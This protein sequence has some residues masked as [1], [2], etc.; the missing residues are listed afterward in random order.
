MQPFWGEI[1]TSTERTN[2][3]RRLH[4]VWSSDLALDEILDEMAICLRCRHKPGT[5]YRCDVCRGDPEKTRGCQC[6]GT[7]WPKP[8]ELCAASGVMVGM[9]LEDILTIA[10][11]M[12]LPPERECE[13]Y[14]PTEAE[15]R[16]AKAR[17]RLGHSD[18]Q[19][20]AAMRGT[21]S[22]GGDNPCED[23][24]IDHEGASGSRHPRRKGQ[25]R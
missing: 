3:K 8:C 1:I 22:S 18:A 2:L 15:I 20:E 7:G 24:R 17:I 23:H 14:I 12:G 19:R 16:I 4:R 6:G 5:A 9:T 10:A 13:S 11:D 21:I 25:R